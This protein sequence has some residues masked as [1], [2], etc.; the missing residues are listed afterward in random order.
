MNRT[1]AETDARRD[2]QVRDAEELLF[3]GPQKLGLAKG[4]FLGRF[5]SDWVMPYP[6]LPLE[7]AAAADKAVAELR[8]FLDEHLDPAAI[9]RQADIPRHVIEGLAKLG[10]LGM[11]APVEFGGRD[12]SQ[13]A[14]CRVMQEIGSRCSATSIFVNA[15]HSIGIRALLLFGTPEQKKRWLP[16]LVRG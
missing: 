16:P 14:Y 15:H 12:F 9:D 13:M 5:V 2:K 6:Q 8:R 11:T 7:Q 1:K 4:L 3:T 10:I